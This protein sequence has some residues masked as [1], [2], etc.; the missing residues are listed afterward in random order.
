VAQGLCGDPGALGDEID[1]ALHGV[2]KVYAGFI[3]IS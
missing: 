3:G 2:T 1:S